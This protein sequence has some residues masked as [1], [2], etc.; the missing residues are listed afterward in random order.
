[1]GEESPTFAREARGV[2]SPSVSA[3]L[4]E[5]AGLAWAPFALPLA[6]P[7]AGD[8]WKKRGDDAGG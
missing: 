1:M 6:A 5:E 2:R 8:D 3:P 4:S 7:G